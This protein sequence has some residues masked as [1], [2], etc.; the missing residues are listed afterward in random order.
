MQEKPGMSPSP[1]RLDE[2]HFRS[3]LGI[4]EAMRASLGVTSDFAMEA[5]SI[6]AVAVPLLVAEVR[7]KRAG[8]GS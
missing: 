1:T 8:L 4:C 7:A 6:F 2:E 5:L 3:L